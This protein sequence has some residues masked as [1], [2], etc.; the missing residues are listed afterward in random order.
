MLAMDSL[1]AAVAASSSYAIHSFDTSLRR[2][3]QLGDRTVDQIDGFSASAVT[4]Q[5]HGLLRADDP[6]AAERLVVRRAAAGP[7]RR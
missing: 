2:T 1:P 3:T 4:R 7:C 5:L 6:L